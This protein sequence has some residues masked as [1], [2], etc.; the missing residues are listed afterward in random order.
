M[1]ADD[2]ETSERVLVHA[3]FGRDGAL[4]R[5]VL[6]RAGIEGRTCRTVEEL[7][8]KILEGAGAAI[9][10]DEAL[11]VN[12]VGRLSEDLAKQGSWSDFPLLIMTSAGEE[13]QDSLRLSLLESLG[14]VSLLERPLRKATLISSV[15]SA[16]RARRRQYQIRDYIHQR[17]QDEQAIRESEASLRRA[18]SELEEFA[19]VASHDIQEPLR[20]INSFT[21]LLVRRHV[22]KDN[23]QAQEYA[24]IV[25][26]GVSRV[27][28]LIQD[29]LSY[30]QMIQDGQTTATVADLNGSLSEALAVL[31]EHIQESGATILRECLPKVIG[32][33]QQLAHV[34][35][36]LLSNAI[37]Y[38]RRDEAP[39]VRITA[40]KRDDEWVIVVEDNGI[41]FE[42][43]YAEKI[44]GLFKRLHRDEYPGTGLGLAICKRIVERYGGRMWADSKPGIGSRFFFALAAG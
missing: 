20:M 22:S 25:R 28:R 9:I 44:F 34:F 12:V 42:N 43:E 16:L 10:A 37:K 36:N 7:R 35:Q 8:S 14:N 1:S 13:M 17:E 3:P 29:L 27:E 39:T 15:R 19:Y 24:A 11:R 40:M 33:E 31:K 30:S 38:R 41:G 6:E 23:A 26:G 18:N 4:I 5:E 32:D 2:I 21:Q